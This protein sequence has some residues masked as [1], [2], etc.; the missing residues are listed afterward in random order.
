MEEKD[1]FASEVIHEEKLQTK[2]WFV[3]C[4]AALVV[5]AVSNMA[6][7]FKLRKGDKR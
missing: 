4:M 5:L 6:W 7:C 1:T 3:A 2:K